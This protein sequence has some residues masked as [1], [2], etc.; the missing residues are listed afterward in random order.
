MKADVWDGGHRIPFVARWPGH[1]KAGTTSDEL[2][3]LVDLMATC[4]AILGE[5]LP[6]NAAEDSYNILPALLGESGNRPIREAVVHHSGS[7]VFAI[8]QGKWKLITRLG[9]GGWTKPRSA[10]P[11]PDGPKGQLYDMENDLAEQHNLW[12]ERPDIVERL[13]RLLEKYQ[14]EGRSAP[15]AHVRSHGAG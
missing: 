11:K 15:R 6:D 14:A 2:I 8:R 1:T 7:G 9:S 4:A 10:K 3:C 5:D 12:L 13:T